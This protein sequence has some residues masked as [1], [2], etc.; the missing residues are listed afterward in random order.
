MQLMPTTAAS[1]GVR[2]SFDPA[3]NLDGGVRHLG[4]LMDLYRGD[5]RKTLAAYN[6]GSGAVS[7]YGGVPPY[8]ETRD[9]VDRVLR[10]YK[11]PR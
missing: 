8:P 6:A 1:L 2:D 4:W 7:R 9:Y 11:A 3:D 10:R 5:L